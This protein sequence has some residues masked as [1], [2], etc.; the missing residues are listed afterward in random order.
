MNE[1]PS[2][3]DRVVDFLRNADIPGEYYWYDRVDHRYI[4]DHTCIRQ[5]EDGTKL[6]VVQQS[7]CYKWCA[8]NSEYKLLHYEDELHLS[9]VLA[10]NKAD[11]WYVEN[12]GQNEI[13]ER[14]DKD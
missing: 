4:G 5:M 9:Y 8:I 6:I 2:D 3:F 7:G 10:A 1:L 14:L 13:I 11:K 12:F